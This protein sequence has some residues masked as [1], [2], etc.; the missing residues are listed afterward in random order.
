MSSQITKNQHYVPQF[1]LRG[2]G[3]ADEETPKVHI[4]DVKKNVV[5]Q[6]QSIKE[7]FSQN[8][9]YDK[10]NEIENFLSLKIE[11]P[12]AELINK[13]RD[14]DFSTLNNG[15]TELI[16]FMCCQNGR[17]VAGREDALNFINAHFQQIV[18]DLVRLNGLEVTDP[19][20]LTV[21]PSDKDSMRYFTAAQALS[22][23]LDSKGMEDLRLH[24]LVNN[25]QKE[26]ILSDHAVSRYNWL[27]RELKDP[28]IGSMLAK[29]VKLFLPLSGRF[30]L[31]A[32]DSK[33]YKFGK[34]S[35]DVSELRYE[36]DVDWLNQLQMRSAHSFVAFS[37]LSMMSYIQ[38]LYGSFYG[39][40]VYSRN[41]LHLS[42]EDIGDDKLKTTHM[43]YTEQIQLKEK[44][45]FFKVLKR[46][47]RDSQYEERDPVCSQ[48]LRMLKNQVHEDRVSNQALPSLRRNG[49]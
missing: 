21:G 39:K 11:G 15:G 32:Y 36:P 34:R 40:K 27:Y 30:C 47:G 8:F 16:K 31:C 6:N 12:A 43:V 1:L 25:T 46:A 20:S 28:R 10:K 2:F 18:S 29:G 19:K 44:P 45:T 17:T 22:A 14:N 23:V 13:F 33:A 49:F 37:S 4:F 5:R 42:Q 24:V 9:F 3:I 41:G 48:A 38:N 26:F 7:V 35:S